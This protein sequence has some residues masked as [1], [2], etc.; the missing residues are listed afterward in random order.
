MI[1]FA[2]VSLAARGSWPEIALLVDTAHEQSAAALFAEPS[3]Q[4]RSPPG[5]LPNAALLLPDLPAQSKTFADEQLRWTPEDVGL[6]LRQYALIQAY[7]GS[8]Y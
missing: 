7:T 2:G 8:L 1:F 6:T 4:Y 3:I 5:S